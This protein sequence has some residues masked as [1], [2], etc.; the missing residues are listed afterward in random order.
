MSVVSLLER[1][2]NVPTI[3]KHGHTITF[4]FRYPL[5]GLPSWD[6]LAGRTT[7][8]Q[9]DVH[10]LWSEVADGETPRPYLRLRKDGPWPAS[11]VVRDDDFAFEDRSTVDDEENKREMETR[12]LELEIERMRLRM[13]DAVSPWQVSRYLPDQRQGGREEEAMAIE[14]ERHTARH[15]ETGIG[16]IA[17]SAYHHLIDGMG[18]LRLCLAL[19]SPS[20][21][22]CDLGSEKGLAPRMEDRVNI[23]P[24][25]PFI[26]KEAFRELVVPTLPSQRL[27]NKW[28]NTPC[29]PGTAVQG[30]PTEFAEAQ[31]SVHL[32][33]AWIS[34]LKQAGKDNGVETINPVLEVAF[35]LALYEGMGRPDEP[36]DANTLLNDRDDTDERVPKIGGV[37]FST[38]HKVYNEPK[39]TRLEDVTTY[40]DFGIP[41]IDVERFWHLT[42]ETATHLSSSSVRQRGRWAIGMMRYL[43]NPSSFSSPH[44]DSP[45]RRTK[46]AWEDFFWENIE[47]PNPCRTSFGW[48]NLGRVNLPQGCDGMRWTQSASPFELA[49]LACVVGHKKGLEVCVT[50]RQGFAV[51]RQEM[52]RILERFKGTLAELVGESRGKEDDGLS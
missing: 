21:S 18:G 5:A 23:T 8:I 35:V 33:S 41:S 48:S 50:F 9:R 40:D 4:L 22:S 12:L 37:F 1:Y 49:M 24:P 3:T 19:L 6:F 30:K 15:T 2:F 29:W 10:H 17:I 38:M 7:Q 45:D 26:A 43:P 46:T 39:S 47:R 14:N 36:I 25:I 16:Y 28:S 27:R 51:S 52:R 13:S 44:A 20:G 34:K 31:E 42:R 11:D 32:P